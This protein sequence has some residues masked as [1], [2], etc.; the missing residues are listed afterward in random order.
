MTVGLHAALGTSS[1]VSTFAV[2]EASTRRTPAS[3]A[4]MPGTTTQRPEKIVG[5]GGRGVG[6]KRVF[7]DATRGG[8]HVEPTCSRGTQP[9]LLTVHECEEDPEDV[10]VRRAE[11]GGA[12][13]A[14]GAHP[15]GR[16][17]VPPAHDLDD[18][19]DEHGEV[20]PWRA[21]QDA[22]HA[23]GGRRP[24]QEYGGQLHSKHLGVPRRRP[25]RVRAAVLLPYAAAGGGVVR[26]E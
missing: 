13:A 8:V 20:A 14:D 6:C 18:G 12:R 2:A 16:E 15:V 9:R 5:W 26:E 24:H 25:P 22:V 7:R 11:G 21:V 4:R 3:Y 23:Q 1:R 17:R 19:C 10:G